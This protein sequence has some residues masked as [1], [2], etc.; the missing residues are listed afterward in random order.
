MGLREL[1][2]GYSTKIPC[3]NPLDIIKNLLN[4]I[5]DK[6]LEEIKPWYRGFTGEIL[7]KNINDTGNYIYQNKGIYKKI[8]DTTVEITELPIG[9]WTDKYRDYLEKLLYSDKSD[10][11]LKDKQCLVNFKSYYTECEVKFVLKFKNKVLNN[12]IENNELETRLKLI[13]QKSTN[14]GNMHLYNSKGIISKYNSSEQIL[15]EFYLIR[16]AYYIKRKEYLLK[17]YKENMIYI[18]IKLSL[19]KNLSIKL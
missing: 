1:E 6:P 13:D 10:L 14:Y 4:L 5:N 18:I 17:K 2:T 9:T 15:K 12:L 7:F 19:L 8:N 3:H 11:K 16:L